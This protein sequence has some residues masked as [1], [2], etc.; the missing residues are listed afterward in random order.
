[1]GELV[2]WYAIDENGDY[3]FHPEGA[4][5]ALDNYRDAVQEPCGPMRVVRTCVKVA[6]PVAVEL[7]GEVGPESVADA[8]LTMA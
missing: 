6:L 3:G 8:T 5:E 1:M 7:T 2:M 4:E